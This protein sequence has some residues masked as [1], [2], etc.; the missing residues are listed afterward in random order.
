MLGLSDAYQLMMDGSLA[1]AEVSEEGLPVDVG[2]LEDEMERLQECIEVDREEIED[3]ELGDVWEKLHKK[4]NYN[5]PNQAVKV[6]YGKKGFKEKVVH[7]T[8]SGAPSTKAE[9][10]RGMEIDGIES[11][12]NLQTHAKTLTFLEQLQ[13][14]EVDGKVH[15]LY[16]LN[17]PRSYRSSSSHPNG[18]NM[19]I[20]NKEA[21]A[22]VR[23]AIVPVSDEWMIGE[24]DFGQLEVRVAACY[25]KDPTMIAYIEDQS[26]DMHR[27]MAMEIFR[28]PAKEITDDARYS[29]KN[30][31]VFPAFYGSYW[32]NIAPDLWKA[33]DELKLET[34]SGIPMDEHLR[35]KGI[36]SYSDFEHHIKE[37]E[38]H[39]WEERFPVYTEWKE[40]WWREYCRIG[41]CWSLTGFRFDSPLSHNQ[42][43]NYP[44][45]GAA[46][47]C[48]LWSLIESQR[49]IVKEEGMES[50]PI[51]QIHDSVIW[52]FK[53][54]ELQ[55]A[56]NIAY[57]VA[58]QQLVEEW[59]WICV[60]LE[61]DVEISS[62]GESWFHKEKWE[63][64]G[65]IWQPKKK[66]A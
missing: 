24:I 65:H 43:I 46:F 11:Y 48:L 64:A 60:P 16:S 41:E 15:P 40:K 28:L 33:I 17:I 18:Q 1:L 38:R 49:Q 61:V 2:Y 8:T 31:M 54:S 37:V 63:H 42:V 14:E 47:H 20:R 12:L 56:V 52:M 45:Q 9:A 55:D 32:A 50:R 66:A 22:S 7:K 13:R 27:D 34:E 6:I 3:S 59:D 21:A 62:P 39:F 10:L 23:N 5:S 57:D 30:R 36:K 44:V 4:P 53:E 51:G 35:S 19:P 25:H 58:T 26:K 29:A